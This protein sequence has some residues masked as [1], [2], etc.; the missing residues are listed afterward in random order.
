MSIVHIEKT[1]YEGY[2]VGI[3]VEHPGIIISGTNDD[4]LKEKFMELLPEYEEAMKERGYTDEPGD[5]E[6]IRADPKK[7]IITIERRSGGK[8]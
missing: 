4:E 7:E 3:G 1:P 2:C 6:K 5:L 8:Q